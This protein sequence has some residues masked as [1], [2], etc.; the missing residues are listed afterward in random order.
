MTSSAG[1]SGLIIVRFA[2]ELDDGVAHGREV[3]DGRHAREVLQH[4]AGRR[5]GDLAVRLGLRVP[6]RKRRDV[7]RRDVLAVLEAQEVLEQDFQRVRQRV[8]GAFDGVETVDLVVRWNGRRASC[9]RRNCRSL[10]P[11]EEIDGDGAD[12]KRE[13][14]CGGELDRGLERSRRSR[15]RGVDR[16]AAQAAVAVV[17]NDELARRRRAL[18]LVEL[19][20]E[21]A[22]RPC[23]SR[24]KPDRVGGS[25]SSLGN[26]TARAVPTRAAADRSNAHP[27]R[28]ASGFEQRMLVALHDEQ[29]V[30]RPDPSRRRTKRSR[31]GRRRRR[32]GA[33]A[34]GRACSR[35]GRD[36][37]RARFHE[38][39]RMTPGSS[40]RY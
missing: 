7:G 28:R 31:A 40:G 16:R 19:R 12:Y 6:V 22:L 4:D 25:E 3:D 2:A 8:D 38:S 18:R 10:E 29:L 39:S 5:E 34:A 14:V 15:R 26:A 36:A 13:T 21:R 32:C 17:E 20:F 27:S 11:L 37:G 9:G 1:D 35:R 23:G 24:C 33:R 30:A